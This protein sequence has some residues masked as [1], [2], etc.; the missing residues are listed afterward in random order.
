MKLSESVKKCIKNFKW[1]EVNCTIC[2]HIAFLGE[3]QS[4]EKVGVFVCDCCNTAYP[5]NTY[6]GEQGK[7]FKYI[8]SLTSVIC[9]EDF[10]DHIK[11]MES[12]KEPLSKMRD[13]KIL[14]HPVLQDMNQIERLSE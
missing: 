3:S 10:N 11:P 8:L 9:A 12:L 5:I 4:G 2:K 14:L 13:K 7:T 6:P 1:N